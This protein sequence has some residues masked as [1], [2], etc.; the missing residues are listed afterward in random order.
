MYRGYKTLFDVE[1]TLQQEEN[2]ELR[3]EDYGSIK[4][5]DDIADL[6]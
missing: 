4:D 1:D 2:G 3:Q 5:F 6:M